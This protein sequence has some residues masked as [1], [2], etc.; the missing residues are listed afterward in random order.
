MAEFRPSVRSPAPGH[1]NGLL[2]VNLGAVG[3]QGHESAENILV[4]LDAKWFFNI[5]ELLLEGSFTAE[6]AKIC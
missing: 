1:A 3:Y 4:G 2:S 6:L 5:F